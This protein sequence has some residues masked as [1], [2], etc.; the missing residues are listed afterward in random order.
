MIHRPN[1]PPISLQ[2]FNQ[3]LWLTF[4]KWGSN[5]HRPAPPLVFLSQWQLD[6]SICSIQKTLLLSLIP[7]LGSPS[8]TRPS[9][10]FNTKYI[11][12]LMTSYY[13]HCYGPNPRPH[14]LSPN[15]SPCFHLALLQSILK[16]IAKWFCL[17]SRSDYI[18][19]GSYPPVLPVLHRAKFLQQSTRPYMIQLLIISL[20]SS[21]TLTGAKSLQLQLP[22][23][24]SE[25]TPATPLSLGLC[26][27]FLLPQPGRPP[28]R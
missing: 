4:P 16:I 25:K 19:S 22:P 1:Y 11:Q 26:T 17:R 27:H 14:Y 18:I 2:V 13:Q 6:P 7:L 20:T 15:W 10:G 3:L 24:C 12:I 5:L 9:I 28:P 23:C 21:A 8:I